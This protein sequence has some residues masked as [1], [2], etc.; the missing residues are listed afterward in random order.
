MIFLYTP[1]LSFQLSYDAHVYRA[2]GAYVNQEREPAGIPS[3]QQTDVFTDTH[4]TNLAYL[5]TCILS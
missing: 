3:H 2:L 5:I 4:N 1:S